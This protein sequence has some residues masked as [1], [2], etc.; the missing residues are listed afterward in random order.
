MI[1]YSRFFNKSKTITRT[2]LVSKKEVQTVIYYSAKSNNPK[3]MA[4]SSHRRLVQYEGDKIWRPTIAS[5]IAF[6]EGKPTG[7]FQVG[8]TRMN[9][10]TFYERATTRVRH[11]RKHLPQNI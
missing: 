6:V 2:P 7:D 5:H 1:Y 9:S 4:S 11:L 3:V 8:F 10:K